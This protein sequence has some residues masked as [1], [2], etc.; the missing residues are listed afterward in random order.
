MTTETY[1]VIRAAQPSRP[2]ERGARS[3]AI[4]QLSASQGGGGPFNITTESLDA[5]Q[6]AV[7]RRNPDFLGAAIAMPMSLQQPMA[8][9][10]T[11]PSSGESWGLEAVRAGANGRDGSGI[12]VAILD[13]GID[14]KHPAFARLIAQERLVCKDFTRGK[15]VKDSEA[16]DEDGH[17]THCAGVLC[18]DPVDGVRIGVAPGIHKL[19]VGKVLGAQ[20]CD[21]AILTRAIEWAVDQQANVISLS[22][23]FDFPGLISQLQAD[24]FPQALAR[25]KALERYRTNVEMFSALSR[26]VERR[27][28]ESHEAVLFIAATGNESRRNVRADF[29][30]GA[31][32]PSAAEGF[33]AVGAVEKAAN[34]SYK[35]AHYSNGGVTLCGPGSDI[36]SARAGGGWVTMSGTSMATPHVAGVAALWGQKLLAETGRLDPRQWRSR[37]ET[38]ADHEV[39]VEASDFNIVGLGLARGP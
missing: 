25:S 33:I 29:T 2:L 1:I 39:V 21:S 37:I 31:A 17:G 23:G 6:L 36:S 15:D 35:V 19:L 12:T 4:E 14:K 13:T 30:V 24:G 22:L 5:E 27:A 7:Q 32:P 26:Y 10:A 20:G 28:A 18:G 11:E 9:T 3:F 38:A 34:N 16:P 8:R